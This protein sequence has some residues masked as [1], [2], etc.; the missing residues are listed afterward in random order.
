MLEEMAR[1]EWLDERE[2]RAWRGLVTMRARLDASM[3]RSLQERSGLSDA[4]YGVLVHLSEA[5]RGR[6]RPYEL[7]A[8]LGW[9]KSRLSHQLRRMEG[10]GLVERAACTTDRR[11]AEAVITRA[12]RAAIRAAA[13]QHAADVRAW[14]VDPLTTAQLDELGTISEAVIAHLDELG[15]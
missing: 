14:F 4:D 1:P 7:A 8:A 9:E 10:R 5:P 2:Q 11:G 6:L 13:P 12:G 15:V 3:R